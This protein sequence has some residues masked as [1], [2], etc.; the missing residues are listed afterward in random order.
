VI[1]YLIAVL[2]SAVLISCSKDDKNTSENDDDTDITADTNLTPQE[3]FS[4]SLL[5]DFLNDSADEDLG[6]Y[7]ESEIYKMGTNYKGASVVEISPAV[8]FIMVEKDT[9]SQNYLLQKFVD[10]KTND[11]YFKLKQ[12]PLTLTDIITK[13]QK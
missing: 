8:W 10:F 4:S 12:T 9:L 2:L 1:K 5:I 3:K 11:Y 13:K 6:N 7:F